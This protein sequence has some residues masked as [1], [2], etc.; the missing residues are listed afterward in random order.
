MVG[1]WMEGMGYSTIQGGVVKGP[2]E[3]ISKMQ[4]IEH[5]N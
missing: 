2:V 3:F 1:L 5:Q 4:F